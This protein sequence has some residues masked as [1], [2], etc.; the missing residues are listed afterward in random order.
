MAAKIETTAEKKWKEVHFN[1]FTWKSGVSLIKEDIDFIKLLLKS[2]AF[3]SS[4]PNLFERLQEY[5]RQVIKVEESLQQLLQGINKHENE[6]GNRLAYDTIAYDD[7][8]FNTHELLGDRYSKCNQDFRELKSKIFKY[9]GSVLK[10][11]QEKE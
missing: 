10:K 4:T 2:S 1:I 8:Y 3:E 6:L 9:T 11:N 7:A 5:L